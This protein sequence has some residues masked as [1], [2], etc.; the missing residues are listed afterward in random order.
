MLRSGTTLAEQILASHPEIFGA[1][2]LP[3]WSRAAEAIR[4]APDQTTRERRL[5]HEAAEYLRTLTSQAGGARRVVDK[6]PANFLSLGLIHAALPAARVIHLRRHPL[7]TCLSIYF[8]H[9]ET[10]LS[11]TNDLGDLARYYG[12]YARL[13]DH[14]HSLFPPGIILDVP[15]EALVQDPEGWS[16]KMIEHIGLPWDAHCLV[17]HSNPRTVITA[18]KWQVRQPVTTSAV[19]RWRNYRAQ[20]G[21]LLGL[22]PADPV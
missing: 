20:V 2:E 5:E 14:W 18:S 9:L 7:D 11:Y 6:M 15:Y 16:R 17:F 3:F 8:Q 13:M 4:S 10:A 12:D 19:G 22:L 21:P 1:G